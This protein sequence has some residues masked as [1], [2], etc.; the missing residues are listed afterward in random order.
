MALAN[1]I[2]ES[3]R[4]HMSVRSE[5][6]EYFEVEVLLPNPSLG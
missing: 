5:P 3:H 6:N 1:A 4:D 2:V